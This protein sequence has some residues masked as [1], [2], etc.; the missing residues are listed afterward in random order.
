MQTPNKGQPIDYSYI[1]QIVD[2]INKIQTEEKKTSSLTN[3]QDKTAATIPTKD[4]VIVTRY[5]EA[6]ISDSQSATA[7]VKFDGNFTTIPIITATL[8]SLKDGNDP[9]R[10]TLALENVTASGVD[11]VL[12]STEKKAKKVGINVIAIGQHSAG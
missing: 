6:T 10:T 8:V 7:S 2:N 5:V 3:G 12:R 4:A 9:E 11:I 1:K